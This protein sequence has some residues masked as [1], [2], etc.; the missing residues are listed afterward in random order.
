MNF[1]ITIDVDIDNSASG[2][3]HYESAAFLTISS[4]WTTSIRYRIY[5]NANDAAGALI[6]DAG[7]GPITYS[8][9]TVAGSYPAIITNALPMG[10]ETDYGVTVGQVGPILV[11]AS[12][13]YESYNFEGPNESPITLSTEMVEVGIHHLEQLAL[14]SDRST[15]SASATARASFSSGENVVTNDYLN[16]RNTPS[17]SANSLLGQLSPGTELTV[18]SGPVTA[19]NE[20]W[21]Q[22]QLNDGSTAWVVSAGLKAL[23]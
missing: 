9:T 12:A 8:H 10:I 17:F 22:I 23:Q 14:T 18:I 7:T 16:L 5:A 4:G 15:P 3:N 11:S 20:S 13:S 21:Y 19:E 2:V 1:P 6:K